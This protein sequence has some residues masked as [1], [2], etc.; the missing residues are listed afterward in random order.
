MITTTA[1]TRPHSSY[2]SA[3]PPATAPKDSA[4][5]LVDRQVL[6]RLRA[7]LDGSDSAW[8]LFVENFI[9]AL[10][11]RIER[12]RLALTTGDLAGSLDAIRSLKTASQMVGAERLA[13][14]ALLLEMDQRQKTRDGDPRVVLPRL[15]VEH[16]RRIKERAEQSTYALETHLN[17]PG[18]A[19]AA[20]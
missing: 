10:P 19:E 16:L 15:A 3:A 6:D 1:R 20:A 13:D 7:D 14:L 2:S 8:R 4:R 18:R 9:S 5:P 11:Q 12:L 17:A